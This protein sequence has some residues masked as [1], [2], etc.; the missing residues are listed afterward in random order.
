MN[1]NARKIAAVYTLGV[2]VALAAAGP[3]LAQDATP[4][5]YQAPGDQFYR[6]PAAAPHGLQFADLEAAMPADP[7]TWSSDPGWQ[8]HRTPPSDLADATDTLRAAI[9]VG[10]ATATA[11]TLLARAGASCAGGSDAR[12]VC[13]YRDAETPYAGEYFDNVLWRVWL[14]TAGGR[15]THVEL[16]RDWTRH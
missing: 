10:T 15:V 12:L 9:P 11:A 8:L 4:G 7:L 14:D 6:A 5:N 1:P 2:A 13:R 3:A 16:T